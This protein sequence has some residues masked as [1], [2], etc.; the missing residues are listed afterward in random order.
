MGERK[1]EELGKKTK[2]KSKVI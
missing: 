2:D 1:K